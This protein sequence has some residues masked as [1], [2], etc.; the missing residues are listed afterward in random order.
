LLSES[1]A[2]NNT[3]KEAGYFEKPVIVC[4]NVGD[5]SDYIV[6]GKNGFLLPKASPLQAFSDRTTKLYSDRESAAQAGKELKKTVMSSFD[7]EAVGQ[8]YEALQQKLSK[9]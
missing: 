7:I 6:D 3:V 5:F 8:Q 1:E 9:S 4:E 2:S